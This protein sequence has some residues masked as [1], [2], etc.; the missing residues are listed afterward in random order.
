MVSSLSEL[1][2]HPAPIVRGKGLLVL[3][4][5]LLGPPGVNSAILVKKHCSQ[6]KYSFP[7]NPKRLWSSIKKGGRFGL[8]APVDEPPISDA[9]SGH[10]N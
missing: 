3:N 4:L 8:E 6:A 2:S 10:S 5:L 1:L 9:T 7:D